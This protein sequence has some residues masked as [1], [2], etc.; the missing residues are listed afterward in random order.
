MNLGEDG[1]DV[2][3]GIRSDENRTS[4]PLV[5]LI[6][7]EGASHESDQV[8]FFWKQA[9]QAR[10]S[11]NQCLDRHE[12]SRVFTIRTAMETPSALAAMLMRGN[13]GNSR[14]TNYRFVSKIVSYQM[15]RGSTK[16]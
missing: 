13:D 1:V 11:M 3:G 6:L 7:S 2:G 10:W 8:A 16:L 15:K 5:L 9:R 4:V 14:Y 12:S